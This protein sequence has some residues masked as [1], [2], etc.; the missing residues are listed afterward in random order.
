M[1]LP[2]GAD[3]L[4]NGASRTTASFPRVRETAATLAG[5][6]RPRAAAAPNDDPL[7]GRDRSAADDF[8]PPWTS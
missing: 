6:S 4:K 7:P 1:R 5:R 8:E 3:P 2:R